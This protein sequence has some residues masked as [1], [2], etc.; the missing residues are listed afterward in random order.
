[1]HTP[2]SLASSISMDPLPIVWRTGD[3]GLYEKARVGR[4][5]NQRRPNRYPHAV[6]EAR[7]SAHVVEAVNLAIENKCRIS[8]RSGGHNWSASSL[9]DNSI[10]VDL[11]NCHEITL[12]QDTG[13]VQVSP[14][15]TSAELNAFLR[16]K[17]RMF[18]GGHCPD[19]A[20]GGFLLLGGVGWNTRVSEAKVPQMTRQTW[21]F[22]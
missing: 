15:T 11:G 10:L 18:A 7:N 9:R 1:M 19:V 5:F 21:F 20:V 12:D 4:I 17:G 6:V 2:F 3:P 8:V 14:S 22:F 13:V 16:P